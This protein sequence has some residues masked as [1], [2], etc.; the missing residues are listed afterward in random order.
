MGN[1]PI[2]ISKIFRTSASRQLNSQQSRL[3]PGEGVAPLKRT[4]EILKR[5]GYSGPASMEL[6]QNTTPVAQNLDPFQVAS[7]SE[8]RDRTSDRVSKSKLAPNFPENKKG[9]GI[10]PRAFLFC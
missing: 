10:S 8:G 3:F 4:I 2:F 1:W 6:F 5:K 9:P 7:Q